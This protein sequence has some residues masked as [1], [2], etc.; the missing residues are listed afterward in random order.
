MLLGHGKGVESLFSLRCSEG[1]DVLHY[2]QRGHNYGFETHNHRRVQH[3]GC[4]D[5]G[6]CCLVTSPTPDMAEE[7]LPNWQGSLCLQAQEKVSC[8]AMSAGAGGWQSGMPF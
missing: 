2:Y 1:R 4:I 7:L 5:C 6:A 8:F 3:E